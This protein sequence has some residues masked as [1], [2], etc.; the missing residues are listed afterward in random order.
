[1][2]WVATSTLKG[3]GSGYNTTYEIFDSLLRSRQVQSP[4]PVGGRLTSQTLYDSRGLAVSRQS[5]I[6]DKPAAPSGTA[7]QIDGGQTPRAVAVV[8]LA[9]PPTPA[10]VRRRATTRWA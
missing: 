6:W 5:D 8:G 3:D 4:S 10:P 1:M 9:R 2:P 7:V